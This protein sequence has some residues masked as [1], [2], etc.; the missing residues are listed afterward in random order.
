MEMSARRILLVDPDPRWSA[1]TEHALSAA[2]YLAVAVGTF[3]DA[4]RQLA[5]DCPDLLVTAARLGAFN[6]LHLVLR[7]REDCSG[8]SMIVTGEEEDPL[9]EAEVIRY[10][11][12]YASKSLEPERFLRLVSELLT[13]RSPRG[14][15]VDRRWP[16]KAAGL[17]A[18]VWQA[19]AR[20]V[21]LSYGGLRLELPGSPA[22][23]KTPMEVALPTLG[24]SIKAVPRWTTPIEAQ[25]TWWCGAEIAAG[26]SEAQQTWREVVDALS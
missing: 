20:V 4:L 7:S 21:E 19:S 14:Q 22:D 1:T 25:G 17:P 13:G 9:L 23:L 8:M 26:D 15:L 18:T 5:V 11:A 10:G 16:R 24:L 12:R 2:G 6:G 3:E